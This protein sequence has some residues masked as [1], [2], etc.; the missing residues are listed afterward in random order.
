VHDARKV[1]TF[2]EADQE[3][4]AIQLVHVG[5]S[6]AGETCDGPE[7]L[8]RRHD[9]RRSDPRDEDDGRYLPNDISSSE[10]IGHVG[11]LTALHSQVFGRSSAFWL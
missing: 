1:C 3:A 5:D 11:K 4:Q 9:Q 10:D 6:G 7:N 8:S 2:E